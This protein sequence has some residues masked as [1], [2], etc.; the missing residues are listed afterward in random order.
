MA[1]SCKVSLRLGQSNGGRDNITAMAIH[2][3]ARSGPSR[4]FR[5][6]ES[7][8]TSFLPPSRLAAE[9]LIIFWG[10][11]F[12]ASRP[13]REPQ[14]KA[15]DFGKAVQ[16]VKDIVNRRRR[17]G[18][19][20]SA[21]TAPEV[22]E[23]PHWE[24]AFGGETSPPFPDGDA[25]PAGTAAAGVFPRNPSVSGGFRHFVSC[26]RAIAQRFILF[27]S[28]CAHACARSPARAP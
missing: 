6:S 8:F 27:F 24:S 3:V 17:S 12:I 23:R 1:T 20:D 14:L 15:R 25:R 22:D 28:A 19:M 26:V 9:L 11:F 13:D 7:A 4:L 5:T 2:G 21:A 10:L 18:S 16:P